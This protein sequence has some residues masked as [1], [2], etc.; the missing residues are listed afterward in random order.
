MR[1]HDLDD[2]V[3][4]RD[5]VIRFWK[6]QKNEA[7]GFQV[8]VERNYISVIFPVFIYCVCVCEC[9]YGSYRL[10]DITR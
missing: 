1:D 10:L 9:V 5:T 7:L 2:N 6:R 8:P 4:T 3:W